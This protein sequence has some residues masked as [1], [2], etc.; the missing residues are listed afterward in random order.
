MS[1]SA[2]ALMTL[3][4]NLG[5]Q[6]TISE[7]D[8]YAAT[9]L[10]LKGYFRFVRDTSKNGPKPGSDGYKKTYMLTRMGEEHLNKILK[11]ESNV[12]Y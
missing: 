3:A 1:N 12:S 2:I 11:G 6:I 7:E 10:T 9:S 8:F 4:Q 5:G